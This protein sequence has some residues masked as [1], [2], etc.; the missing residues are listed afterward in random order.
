M[1]SHDVRELFFL[2]LFLYPLENIYRFWWNF[3]HLEFDW[4]F[5]VTFKS[6][7]QVELSFSIY[8]FALV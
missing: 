3:C 2:H 4:K 1:M 5:S 8:Y 7:P 6:N